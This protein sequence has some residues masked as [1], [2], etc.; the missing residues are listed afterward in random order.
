M[1]I[2]AKP[3]PLLPADRTKDNP[4][5]I[6]LA[7][8]AFLATLS[9]LSV[10]A[11]Y[12][13]S[14]H[15]SAG[16]HETATI[17]IKP[18][19]DIDITAVSQTAKNILLNAPSVKD[20]E[21]LPQSHSKDLLRPWLGD[22]A[23]PDDLPLPVLLHV[24][25]HTGQALNMSALKTAF[26]TANIRAD[27]DN[28]SQWTKELHARA[29]TV[30]FL[31]LLAFVL[32]AVAILCACVFAIRAGITAQRTLMKVLHQIGAAPD[33]TARLFST[34]FALSGFKAGCIGASG[35]FILVFI[36]SLF[37]NTLFSN[38][39][40]SDT[41][42]ANTGGSTN[43]LPGFGVGL[44]EL[45]LSCLIPLIIALISGLAAWHT[46]LKSLIAEM[47]S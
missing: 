15:W 17:Q 1:T 28:H 8:L 20:V 21:I 10:K 24:Q 39:G 43:L 18:T 40:F 33:Y 14:N 19:A 4:L 47:Y 34:R 9:L 38:P 42:L 7:I 31:A 32:I 25:L 46:T 36:L 29:R 35:A 41:G 13:I 12:Q 27:I 2:N 45:Y 23:L 22:A 5:F 44:K 26:Q 30:R 6:V 11:S 37:S 16:L 3:Q